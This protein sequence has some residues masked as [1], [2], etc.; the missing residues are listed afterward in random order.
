MGI[1]IKR[2]E[3]GVV[4]KKIRREVERDEDRDALVKERGASGCIILN[5]LGQNLNTMK[6][7]ILV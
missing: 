1:G 4:H 3:K 5:V 2:S 7:I 6:S